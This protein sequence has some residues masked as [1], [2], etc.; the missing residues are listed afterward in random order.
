MINGSVFKNQVKNKQANKSTILTLSLYHF[1][2]CLAVNG[3]HSQVYCIIT[4][5]LSFIL[6][7]W[8]G[9]TMG[10]AGS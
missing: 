9:K 3:G 1:D 10:Q 7:R 4:L 8:S 6:S 2:F 5:L